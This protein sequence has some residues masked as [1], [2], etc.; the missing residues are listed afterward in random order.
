M[1]II[2][3]LVTHNQC[4]S[5]HKQI[6]VKGLMLHSVGCS[7]PSALAFVRMFNKASC[8]TCVHAFIDGDT[9]DVQQTLP[10]DFRAWHAGG[11]ANATHIGIEMCEPSTIRYTQGATFKDKDTTATNAVVLRTYKSAVELFVYLCREFKLD[12]LADGT[13]ISHSEGHSRG[14]ASGHVDPEHLWRCFGLA[15]DGFRSEVAALL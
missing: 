6:K 11:A 7:Q 4:Y 1:K 10:W 5:A 12:P 14:L 9:G 8:G 2:E 13:I 3:S 15:M